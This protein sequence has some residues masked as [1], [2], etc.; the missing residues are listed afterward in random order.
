MAFAIKCSGVLSILLPFANSGKN[1]GELE[2]D[3]PQVVQCSGWSHPHALVASLNIHRYPGTIPTLDHCRWCHRYP[4]HQTNWPK[5]PPK[6]SQVH[7]VTNNFHQF[8]PKQITRIFHCQHTLQCWVAISL[9]DPPHPAPS[10]DRWAHIEL[11]WRGLNVFFVLNIICLK[12][13]LHTL[14]ITYI[15]II[16]TYETW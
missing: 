5:N 8:P 10:D 6:S 12:K 7:W 4:N 9:S 3:I 13:Y 2:L 11:M 14:I 1:P 15:Y 16:I